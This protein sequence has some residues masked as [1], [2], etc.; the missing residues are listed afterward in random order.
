[1]V[2]G[3]YHFANTYESTGAVQASYFV[4]HG[5]TWSNDGQTLPPMLDIEYDPYTSSDGTNS[6]YGLSQPAMVAW[7]TKFSNTVLSLTGTLPAIYTT[8]N[9]WNLCTG[10]NRSFASNSLLVAYWV[11]NLS[12]GAGQLPATWNTY[13]L[14]QYADSGVFLGD[15]D[16]VQR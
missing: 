4:T 14:W 15:Q 3:A 5:G 13:S 1:M 11:D 12:T 6:C 10:G 7:I 8:T 9:W 16:L 2:R